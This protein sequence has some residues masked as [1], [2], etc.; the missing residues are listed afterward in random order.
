MAAVVAK[1]GHGK[2]SMLP[3][4]SFSILSADGD[5]TEERMNDGVKVRQ[6]HQTF[7]VTVATPLRVTFVLCV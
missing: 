7:M 4:I 5:V 1:C 3:G 6:T 2:M